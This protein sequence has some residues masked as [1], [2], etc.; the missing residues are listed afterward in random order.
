MNS[1][2]IFKLAC[3]RRILS[4]AKCAAIPALQRLHESHLCRVDLAASVDAPRERSVEDDVEVRERREDVDEVED[5]PGVAQ[6]GV[7]V[8]HV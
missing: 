7:L 3:V 6:E 1:L 8:V 4:R 2:Q 5:V